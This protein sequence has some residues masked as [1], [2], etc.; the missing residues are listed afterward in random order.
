MNLNE[1]VVKK[2]KD[3]KINISALAEMGIINYIKELEN[4]RV[5]NNIFTNTPIQFHRQSSGRIKD[6]KNQVGPLRFEL[7]S[8]APEATRIPSYPTSPDLQYKNRKW[9]KDIF[10][11]K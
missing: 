7:R 5:E 10:G 6:N 8:I 4:I 3:L 1:D 9:I 11:K 2:A